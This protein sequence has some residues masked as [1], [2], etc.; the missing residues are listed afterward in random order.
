MKIRLFLVVAC[1]PVLLFSQK[2]FTQDVDNFW[3]TYDKIIKTKDS[4]QKVS[5]IQTMYIDKGTQG[6]HDIMKARRYSTQEYIDAI[7]KYPKFWSSIRSRTLKSKKQAK[8]VE[9]SIAALKKIYPEAKPANVY[10]TVGLLRTNGTTMGGNVLIGAESALADKDVDI[11]EMPVNSQLKAYFQTNPINSFVSLTAHEYVHTQQKSTIGKNLL[12]QVVMEGVAEFVSNLS[13]NKKSAVPAMAYGYAHEAEIK[14]LFVK[15][16]FTPLVNTASNWIWNSSNNRF[17]IADLG[18]FV[19]NEIAR[20]YYENQS[21]KKAAIKHMIE[22]DYNK[23][24]VLQKFVDE[25]VYFEKPVA[26]YVSGY[27]DNR[28]TVIGIKEFENGS[29]SVNPN[30]KIITLTFSEPMMFFT[31]FNYGPLGE[32]NAMKIEKLLGYSEDKKTLRLQIMNLKPNQRYQL[33]IDEGFRSVNDLPLKSYLI[34]FT[35]TK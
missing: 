20:K 4:A 3:K 16:M 9:K 22:L 1:S 7:G 24:S 26:Q 13:L 34:D 8:N 19:G 12:T 2:V 5:L 27:E 17:G 14:N 35:T 25:S 23:E 10:F 29:K 31:N 30:T 28:P 6:L 11:S 32:G 18:Y 21:D 15:E 33:L